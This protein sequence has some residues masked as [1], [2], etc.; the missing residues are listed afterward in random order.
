LDELS[1]GVLLHSGVGCGE[2]GKI[3]CVGKEGLCLQADKLLVRRPATTK[4]SSL[5]KNIYLPE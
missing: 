1:A 4:G 3:I 2:Q 5:V